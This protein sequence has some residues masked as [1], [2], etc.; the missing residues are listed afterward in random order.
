MLLALLGLMSACSYNELPA[1]VA[2][3]VIDE[4]EFV[5]VVETRAET[6]KGENLNQ[7]YFVTAEDLNNFVKFRRSASKRSGL[8]VREVKSYGFDSSQT[9]FYILNYNQGWEV[10]SADKRTPPTLAH[11]DSGE[12]TMDCDN[13]A[14]KYW[15]N[16]LADGVLQIRLHNDIVTT[17]STDKTL[18]TEVGSRPEDYVGFWEAISPS[19]SDTRGDEI[20]NIPTPGPMTPLY[21][22]YQVDSETIEGLSS[23]YGPY[24][25]TNWDQDS[26]WNTFC[27]PRTVDS[28]E[29]A[30][31]GCVAV[32]GAQMLY[33]LHDLFDLMIPTPIHC[34]QNGDITN[35]QIEFDLFRYDVWDN[36]A[37][38][39]YF[40]GNP[41]DGYSYD[42]PALLMRFVGDIIGTQYGINGS[43]A[44]I[45]DLVNVFFPLYH[46]DC[47]YTESYSLSTITRN[48]SN[49]L[50]VL[51]RGVNSLNGFGHVWIADGYKCT[52]NKVINYY[53]SYQEPKTD[54]YLAL[55]D[56]DDAHYS[57]TTTEIV[58]EE[59]HMNWGL[60]GAGNGY[61]AVAPS[62]WVLTS[63]GDPIAIYQEYVK[64]AHDFTLQN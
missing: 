35:S 37:L 49:R 40:P 38:Y 31:V 63:G 54:V 7:N 23:S 29:R 13:E 4:A 48:L 15:M 24:I 60:G 30:L 55:L 22:V 39:D 41:P 53:V 27:P 26:P 10:V 16:L 51:M 1:N 56:K 20:I 17:A 19:T 59:L 58:A 46:I 47:T 9:L 28:N 36:M 25:A 14:M 12:F 11:G 57:R 61:F 43:G 34:I 44:S 62:S 21:Y 45:I 64:M 8:T 32:A 33:Y 42:Y 18:T 3:D 52:Y 50:P 5:T 6:Y 2:P